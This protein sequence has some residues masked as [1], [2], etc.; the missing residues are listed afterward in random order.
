MTILVHG[1]T[2][3]QGSP[4]LTALRSLGLDAVGAGRDPSAVDGA[5]VLADYDDVDGLRSAYQ[6]AAG[7]FVHLPVGTPERQVRA[8]RAVATALADSPVERVV[9]STSGYPLLPGSG[10][11]VL[12]EALETSGRS[13]A[14]V[15]PHLFLENLLLPTVLAA[16]R[17]EG[18][19]RY[20]IRSD[21]PLSWVSH[22]DVADVAVALLRDDAVEGRVG[23]GA[24]PALTGPD[25]AAGFARHLGR[26]VVFEEQDPEAFGRSIEPLFG[27]QAT[28]PIVESYIRL[29]ESEGDV[30]EPETSAQQRLGVVPREVARWLADVG[31]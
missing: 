23:V 2:G 31:V 3:A 7:V 4:V 15:V 1:A 21:I 18:V 22:L 16:V 17:Q 12:A 11:A 19:L 13:T 5:A 6:Q 8:A 26:D 10:P 30:V 27:A 20:P 28:R 24:L 29:R 25:L 9:A 14:V